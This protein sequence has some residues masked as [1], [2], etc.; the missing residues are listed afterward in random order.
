MIQQWRR[1]RDAGLEASTGIYSVRI[2]RTAMNQR[3]PLTCALT[4]QMSTAVLSFGRPNP[5][6]RDLCTC[7]SAESKRT[8]ITDTS[9]SLAKA[10]GI[11]AAFLNL[12]GLRRG[13]HLQRHAQTRAGFNL[14]DI[15]LSSLNPSN[16]NLCWFLCK[17]QICAYLLGSKG[18][19]RL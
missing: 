17:T 10:G 14:L 5:K 19:G 8:K 16:P 18:S 1:E 9:L 15:V 7:Q 6:K 11:D 12:C 4:G 13:V 2:R 3:R